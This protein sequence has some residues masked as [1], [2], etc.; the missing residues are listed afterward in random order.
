MR[1][2][3]VRFKNI[4]SLKGE[5]EINFD[6]SP[7]SDTG[8]FA[9]T[10]PNGAGK[11]SILD[12]LS[13]G[14]YGQT[15]RNKNSD[16][17][18]IT[19]NDSESC[20]EVTFSV[21]HSVFKSKWSL[22][23]SKGKL[24]DPEMTLAVINGD[25]KV[26]ENKVNA[27]RL[28]IADITGLDFKRFCR[29]VML[30]QGESAAFL[31][32]LDNERA[33][34]L[35]KII[36][37][38]IFSQYSQDI[39]KK[40]D[41]E[42]EKLLALKQSIQNFSFEKPDN[43]EAHKENIN[44]L[45]SEYNKAEAKLFM[46][47]DQDEK[48]KYK[49]Q[50][51]KQYEDIQLEFAYIQDKKSQKNE[52]FKRLKKA[53]QSLPLESGINQLDIYEKNA[54]QILEKKEKLNSVI[55]L[56]KKVLKDLEQEKIKNEQELETIQAR[57]DEQ[58]E[59]LEKAIGFD[60]DIESARKEFRDRVDQLESLEKK[61]DDNL[62]LQS[63]IKQKIIDK[64]IAW[65]HLD[66]QIKANVSHENLDKD[67]FVIKNQ[68]E[69]ISQ[70]GKFKTEIQNNLD[71][72]LP[73]EKKALAA[74]E[75]AENKI[76][77][78]K[79]KN[80]N[81]YLK[82]DK[83]KQA[84]NNMLNGDVIEDIE[85]EY[86]NQKEKLVTCK[87]L[88]ELGKQYHK[89][90]LIKEK[91][92]NA[93]TH[94]LENAQTE[95]SQ[96]LTEFEAEQAKRDELEYSII[97][98]KYNPDR[99]LL[100]TN[101]PCPLCGSKEHPFISQ[102]LPYDN[103]P[104]HALKIQEKKL[105]DINKRTKTLLS[106]INSLTQKKN[107]IHE[108]GKQWKDLC[109]TID[110]EW[111]VDD[112]DSAVKN[113]KALKKEVKVLAKQLKAIRKISQKI[114]KIQ[115][116]IDKNA[117]KI[118]N[119]QMIADQLKSNAVIQKNIVIKLKNDLEDINQKTGK[120]KQILNE[121]LEKYNTVIPSQGR[122]GE[123]SL[124]LET[125]KN[126]YLNQKHQAETLTTELKELA[127][128]AKRLPHDLAQF[129]KQA[130]NLEVLV[131][132]SQEKQ[133]KLEIQR[134]EFYGSG[135]PVVEKQVFEDKINACSEKQAQIILQ[136]GTAARELEENL[137][138]MK[139][140]ETEYQNICKEIES[141]KNFLLS[142]AIASGFNNIDEIR[143]NILPLENQ[144]AIENEQKE[145]EL[146]LTE[147]RNK[148]E[149]IK[150][151]REQT[152]NEQAIEKSPD[153]IS[154]EIQD[155]K[156]ELEE[157]N[158]DLKLSQEIIKDYESKEREYRQRI[159]VIED[160]EKICAE[161][162][163]EKEYINSGNEPEIKKRIQTLMF[164]QLI[165]KTNKHLEELSG[166]YYIRTSGEQGLGLEIEDINQNRIRR[167]PRSLS[168]GESFQVSM[169]LALGL[170]DLA[171]DNR[172]IESLFLDEGFG[173][174]DDETLYKVITTLKNIKDNNKTVGIISHVKKIEDE[175]PTRIRI[176][177]QSGGTSSIKVMA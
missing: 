134:T 108:L 115:I 141:L 127:K 61:Q 101:K 97:I 45:E 47:K 136:T 85:K 35:E 107:Q 138:N 15:A 17:Y 1:I 164:E 69:K 99:K 9:I 91:E 132:E 11:T 98:S 55:P 157:L 148:L 111:A 57:Q 27:V 100:K 96:L 133:T 26:L 20:S 22:K 142:K 23:N 31:N 6:Q 71:S 58:I 3:K 86:N 65:T 89:Q 104:G 76:L 102:G 43:I 41:K 88:V 67:I 128:Q 177:K 130:D 64:Q 66:K 7:L 149:E 78:I 77:K 95:Y 12:A 109:Q 160:Q 62:N 21:N 120:Q 129:K 33:E 105:K 68:L 54:A 94:A 4:N 166:R 113:T 32:A 110:C 118:L 24:L 30:A 152:L 123:L 13:L 126:E 40:A 154:L 170:S 167:S 59:S 117:D 171:S 72:A 75:K 112:I 172:K 53:Q 155:L 151:K 114:I 174:L 19:K 80:E 124:N 49:K 38:Q 139:Q 168:G 173:T 16:K 84:L 150:N 144:Q 121:Y 10:G 125:L 135:D 103:N 51:Q 81:L 137:E 56:Q 165:E 153:E 156:K 73:N 34:I 70:A 37:T 79:K 25:E 5:W 131:R 143:E 161:L 29:T 175:I 63:E 50:I 163:A 122:E 93:I 8:I 52:K 83:K 119:K 87:K 46:L 39:I 146:E 28:K 90:A 36:G 14:L 145:L 2:L 74:Q 159:K 169:A 147:I 18:I 140:A 162:N 92:G 176:E 48:L 42:N 106:Q 116:N 44:R 60:R 158:Q 82:A